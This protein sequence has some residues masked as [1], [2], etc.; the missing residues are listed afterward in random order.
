MK[1]PYFAQRQHV[2]FAVIFGLFVLFTI[3]AA[4]V[5]AATGTTAS[6]IPSTATPALGE[7]FTVNITVSNVQNLYGV[8]V[9]LSWN[10]SVLQ[11]LNV[12]LRLGVESHPDGVLHEILPD[13]EIDVVENDVSAETGTYHVAAT[14]VNP[15]PSFSGNGN[16]AVLTFN[17][18][19]LGH[20]GLALETELADYP[21]SGE[22]AN[23]IEH[24]TN[25]GNINVIPEFPTL[26]TIALLLALAT[27]AVAFSK[28][29]LKPTT[30]I[31]Q[32]L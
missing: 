11:V 23:L 22:T 7:T 9:T 8:D 6:S 12:N 1:K 2:V 15:A 25:A 31:T 26:I 13:A 32:I 16:I 30:Q 29:H 5:Q 21:A 18:T 27:A 14:S 17:V 10:A 4:S 19:K 3:Q 20:S 24:T 28:K